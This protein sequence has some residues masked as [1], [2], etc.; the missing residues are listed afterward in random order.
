[1]KNSFLIISICLLSVLIAC[2]KKEEQVIEPQPYESPSYDKGYVLIKISDMPAIID[3]IKYTNYTTGVSNLLTDPMVY[4]QFNNTSVFSKALAN[5]HTGDQVQCCVYL[6]APTN[7]G[8][9]FQDMPIDSITYIYVNAS[10]FC[11][12]GTY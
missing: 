5:G 11:A 6:N 3:S 9:R 8:I 7:I 10:S 2:S 4:Y 12:A 1:M